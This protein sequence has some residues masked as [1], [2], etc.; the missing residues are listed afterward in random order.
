MEL[1]DWS[2][3]GSYAGAVFAV[4]VLTQITKGIRA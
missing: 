1:F 3:L 4:G 2:L